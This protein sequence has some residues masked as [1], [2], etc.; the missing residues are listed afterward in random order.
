MLA[1]DIRPAAEIPPIRSVRLLPG[2]DPYVVAASYHARALLPGD[3][4]PRVYRPQGWIS[5]VLLVN[6]FM[7]GV[8]RHEL[9]GSSVELVIE[10]FVK[11]PAWVRRAATEEAERLADFFGGRLALRFT[12]AP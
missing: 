6:G 5:P 3:F 12:P 1:A 2:F 11:L 8:W 10:P 4:R 9:K 7:H